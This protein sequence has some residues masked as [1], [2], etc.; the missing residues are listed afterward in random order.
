MVGI[1]AE[2][3]MES[4]A[5]FAQAIAFG[6]SFLQSQNSIDDLVFTSLLPR[7]LEKRP[8]RFTLENQDWMTLQMQY[9]VASKHSKCNTGW[10]R[11]VGS[12]K[13]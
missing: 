2:I 11:L 5:D 13:L 12:L 3:M 6:V 9:G 7:S 4:M 10:L 8:I 1:M